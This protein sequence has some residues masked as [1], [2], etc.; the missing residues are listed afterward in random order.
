MK[1][2]RHFAPD[3]RQA[4]QRV[5]E[6]QGP[7]AVILSTRRV[8]G[9]VEVVAAI[10]YD[11]TLVAETVTQ[12]GGET[13]R[14]SRAREQRV[15]T[16]RDHD[17][18]QTGR[19]AAAPRRDRPRIE[20]AQDPALVEMKR[21]IHRLRDLLENQLARLA[22][23][24][25]GRR[26]PLQ[27]ELLRRLAALGLESDFSRDLIGGLDERDDLEAAWQQAL[28]SLAHR[29]SVSGDDIL[30]RGGVL[31]LVGPTGVGKTT[32]LAKLAARFALRH[33]QREVA[34]VSTDGYRIG[35]QDQLLTYGRILGVTVHRAETAEELAAV[36]DGLA[37]RRLVLIDTA[38]MSQ[39]D[40]ALQR[41]M[42]CLQTGE[43]GHRVRRYLVLPATSQARVLHEAVRAFAEGGLDGCV[44]TKL[45]EA[46]TLGQALSVIAAAALPLAYVTD[47]QRVPEDLHPARIN[48]LVARAVTAMADV[49][50]EG[51]DEVFAERFGR[52]IA[53]GHV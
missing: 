11:E 42:A 39:H 28:R 10:D 25:F 27:L 19:P 15:A 37:D 16:R 44:L 46:V 40:L 17:H 22:W 14:P 52:H 23:A 3:M 48:Q 4:I 36:L 47:G 8:E 34:L 26:H 32:T 5:R 30:E 49:S 41:R 43:Q 35:A 20:W 18:G 53:G 29:I 38:G 1:I 9:G 13:P 31:A 24:D 51:D 33:G 50:Q 45:D 7:D 21:E 2:K 6:E 12:G